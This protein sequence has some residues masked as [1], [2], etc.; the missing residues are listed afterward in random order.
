VPARR[1]PLYSKPFKLFVLLLIKLDAIRSKGSARVRAASERS[2][3]IICLGFFEDVTGMLSEP[4]SFSSYP[5]TSGEKLDS[6]A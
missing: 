6:K 4:P 3:A 1:P 2:E 5:T